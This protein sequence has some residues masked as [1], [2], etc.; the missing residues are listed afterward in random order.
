MARKK[1]K[2]RR[3]RG[4]KARHYRERR[5]D[6]Q[7]INQK[8]LIVCEGAKTEPNY[9]SSFQGP[10]LIVDATGHGVTPRQLVDIALDLGKQ[11]NYDQLWCV[12]DRDDWTA[13]D[14]T[15]GMQRAESQGLR[16][17]YSNQ[18][19]ELWYL[20][21]FHYY[22]TSM[23]RSD[24]IEKLNELLPA[25]YR[26][27]DTEIYNQLLWRQATAVANAENLLR[28]YSPPDPANDDP[29][30]TVLLLVLELNKFLP[31]TRA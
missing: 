27:N 11:D 10:K 30:T 18:A 5:F 4:G 19:F 16:V 6:S 8:F 14:F 21:H 22:D 1:G 3:S 26:K 9:F 23:P 15:G 29:S 24:Y 20:L 7:D 13:D 2:H 17:A 28:Q 25:P 12:F 31:D